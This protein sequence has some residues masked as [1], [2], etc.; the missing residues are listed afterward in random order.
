MYAN[1]LK[2]YVI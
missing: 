2:V 1:F